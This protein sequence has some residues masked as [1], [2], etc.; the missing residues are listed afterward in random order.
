[1]SIDANDD[2]WHEIELIHG[3]VESFERSIFIELDVKVVFQI[4]C[5]SVEISG[6][7]HDVAGARVDDNLG[8]ISVEIG[9]LDIL[10]FCE[11]VSS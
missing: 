6:W 9:F 5:E 11:F 7:H 10:A 3:A 1:L 8:R 2:V 4:F